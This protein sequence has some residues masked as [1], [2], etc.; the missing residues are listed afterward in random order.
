ML[1]VPTDVPGSALT[2]IRTDKISFKKDLGFCVPHYHA[3]NRCGIADDTKGADYGKNT[4]G[5]D[6]PVI[7]EGSDTP[8]KVLAGSYSPLSTLS[9]SNFLPIALQ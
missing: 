4:S 8:A 6:S 7:D 2:K 5:K 3:C 9:L 1:A